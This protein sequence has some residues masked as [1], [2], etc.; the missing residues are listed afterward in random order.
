MSLPPSNA[1]R[2]AEELPTKLE[3][4]FGQKT[5]C[6]SVLVPGLCILDVEHGACRAICRGQAAKENGEPVFDDHGL[7]TSTGGMPLV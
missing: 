2:S 6:W 5:R 4:C 3:P 1:L 7:V